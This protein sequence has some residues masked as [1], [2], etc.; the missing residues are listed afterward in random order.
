MKEDEPTKFGFYNV[1][2]V[3]DGPQ[4]SIEFKVFCYSDSKDKG[5]PVYRND[6]KCYTKHRPE[7]QTLTRNRCKG[8][9]ETHG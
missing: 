5:A 2:R 7:R 9:R 6:R 1:R 8:S 3:R 4:N